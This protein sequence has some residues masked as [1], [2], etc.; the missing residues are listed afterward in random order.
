MT[1]ITAPTNRSGQSEIPQTS[2][3]SHTLVM[4]VEDRP[5]AVDRVFGLFR[6]RRANMQTFTLAPSGIADVVRITVVV[7]DS[8]VAVDQ[9]VEQIRK[10]VDVREVVNL[11]S[12]Q[13]VTHELALIKVNATNTHEII[14]LGQLFGAYAVDITSETVTLE[15][16]GSE[17]KIATFVG[18]LQPYGIREVARSGRVAMARGAGEP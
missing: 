5:A 11:Q 16:T 13:A 18:R 14:E 15:V 6:R 2:A 12:Q 1:N 4:L 8:Q 9:L 17:E 3:S 7:D 10:V